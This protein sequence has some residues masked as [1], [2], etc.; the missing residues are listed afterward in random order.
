MTLT[1]FGHRVEGHQQTGYCTLNWRHMHRVEKKSVTLTV[2]RQPHERQ[3]QRGD[4]G[5]QVDVLGLRLTLAV[6]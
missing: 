4:I 3:T 2:G 6:K 1:L 5:F